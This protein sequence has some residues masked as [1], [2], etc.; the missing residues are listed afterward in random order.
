[1]TPIEDKLRAAIR[2]RAGE[3]EPY[4]PPLRLPTGRPGGAGGRRRP[5]QSWL[6]S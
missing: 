6:A 5:P 1:M 2:A 3:I 4:A